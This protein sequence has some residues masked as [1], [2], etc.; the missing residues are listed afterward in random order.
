MKIFKVPG[1]LRAAIIT[2]LRGNA[3]LTSKD[4]MDVFNGKPDLQKYLSY[5]N[6]LSKDERR[7]SYYEGSVEITQRA[8]LIHFYEPNQALRKMTFTLNIHHFTALNK[9]YDGGIGYMLC[10]SD[11][12]F[13]TR[14]YKIGVI[15]SSNG[16]LSLQDERVKAALRF[17]E[18]DGRII[19]LTS[20]VDREWYDL[21]LASLRDGSGIIK[22]AISKT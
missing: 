22:P 21:I 10:T 5:Y 20:S 11:G 1:M 7:C 9:P 19:T 2:G 8:L 18:M 13:D 3:S 14:L 4:V 6:S 12:T 15:S 16:C 17:K